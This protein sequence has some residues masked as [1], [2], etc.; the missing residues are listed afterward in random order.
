MAVAFRGFEPELLIQFREDEGW[1]QAQLAAHAGV[2]P[3][4]ISLW[5]SGHAGP[6]DKSV[7]RLASALGVSKAALCGDE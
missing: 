6:N 4:Q 5:E 3:H 2:S 1:T 7:T